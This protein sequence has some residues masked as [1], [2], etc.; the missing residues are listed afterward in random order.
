MKDI[1]IIKPLIGIGPFRFGIGA[2]DL[3]A[4][5]GPADNYEYIESGETEVWEY[6][7]FG[8][9]VSFD[10]IKDELTSVLCYNPNMT[11]EN[12]PLVFMPELQLQMLLTEA[13][14]SFR[15]ETDVDEAGLE[16]IFNIDL[17]GMLLSIEGGQVGRFLMLPEYNDDNKIKIPETESTY[18]TK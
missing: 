6:E 10:R 17:L 7:E 4:L 8:I 12:Y 3:S 1:T 14:L 11:L 9:N 15:V 16:K 2:D 5:I 18:F 13:G